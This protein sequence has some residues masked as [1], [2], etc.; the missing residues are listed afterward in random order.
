MEKAQ[1]IFDRL[2]SDYTTRNPE[3]KKI[4]DLFISKGEEVLNDHIAFRTFADPRV[5]IDIFSK[6]FTEAGY[7]YKNDY[8]FQDKHLYAKHFEHKD[9]PE[10]PRV[11]ISELILNEFSPDLQDT[12]LKILDLIPTDKLVPEELIFSGN[13]WGMPSF[14]TYS[15]LRTESEYAAWVYVHGYRANHFTINVNAL[16]KYNTL[17]KVNQ[18]LKENGYTLN[19]SSGEIKGTP[20]QLLEQ[21]STRSGI[22]EISFKEGIFRVPSCYYEFA[23]RYR[24][25]DGNLYSGFIAKSADKIFEST[26]YYEK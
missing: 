5:N 20:D 8:H 11:F 13:S 16:K 21:S 3:V 26:D 19:D 6:P 12:I 17:Q 2:W 25:K 4:Y 10:A 22:I 23:K 15:K 14:E 1:K 18:F 9:F 24:D 7:V